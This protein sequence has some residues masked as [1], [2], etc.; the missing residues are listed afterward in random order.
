MKRTMVLHELDMDDVSDMAIER[1]ATCLVW[2][3]QREGLLE[4][5][6]GSRGEQ[7]TGGTLG[8]P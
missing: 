1:H 8:G 7:W 5:E 2:G 6:A 3:E 4:E